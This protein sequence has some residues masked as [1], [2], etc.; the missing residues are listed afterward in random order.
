MK[1]KILPLI[2]VQD[3]TTKLPSFDMQKLAQ[4]Y[5]TNQQTSKMILANFTWIDI[6]GTCR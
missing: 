2:H 3:S 6:F 1:I 5:N 4:E